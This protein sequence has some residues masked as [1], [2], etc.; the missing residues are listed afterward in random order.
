VADE[1]AAQLAA[2]L[3]DPLV[4]GELDEIRRLVLVQ[5]VAADEP[6]LDG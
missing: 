5:V 4:G 6:E 3:L 2:R 1:I